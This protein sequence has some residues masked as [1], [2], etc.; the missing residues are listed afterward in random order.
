MLINSRRGKVRFGHM[1]SVGVRESML[2]EQ[3]LRDEDVQGNEE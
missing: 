3:S 2:S 1:G